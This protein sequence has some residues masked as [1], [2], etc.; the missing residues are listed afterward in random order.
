[1][2]LSGFPEA[3]AN[4]WCDVVGMC[5]MF[6]IWEATSLL[7]NASDDDPEF[8]IVSTNVSPLFFVDNFFGDK[9]DEIGWSNFYA[10]I[11]HMT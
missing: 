5:V 4:F 10:V 7:S 11:S 3:V 8:S 6:S 9:I 1:M 2:M